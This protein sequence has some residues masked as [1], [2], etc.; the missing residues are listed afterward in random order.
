LQ[1]SIVSIK[2]SVKDIILELRWRRSTSFLR[3]KKIAGITRCQQTGYLREQKT[4]VT[5]GIITAFWYEISTI[6]VFNLN[7]KMIIASKN[8]V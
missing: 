3:Y 1:A 5:L 2:I 8:K 7:M 4:E 6:T